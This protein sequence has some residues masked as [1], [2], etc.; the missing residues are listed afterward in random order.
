MSLVRQDY[1]FL[2]ISLVTVTFNRLRLMLWFPYVSFVVGNSFNVI[3]LGLAGYYKRFIPHFSNITSVLT[4]LL[5]KRI[6]FNGV[7]RLRKLCWTLRLVWQVDR[8]LNQ[9]LMLYFFVL[10]LK[11]S[12]SALGFVIVQ[13]FDEIEQP[14]CYFYRKSNVHEVHYLT[15]EKEALSLISAV[16]QVS[17]YL[18]SNP[19]TV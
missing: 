14:V 17:V 3:Y 12:D 15:V 2:V 6:G 7:K 13:V 8:C 4:D 19:V 11:A 10:L 5:K 9:L 16:R 1:N 18:G